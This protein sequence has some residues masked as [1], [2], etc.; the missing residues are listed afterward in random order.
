MPPATDKVLAGDALD[1]VV[2]TPEELTF[3]VGRLLRS[4]SQLL[5][6]ARRGGPTPISSREQRSTESGR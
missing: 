6:V 2:S 1:E 5:D 4:V 3:V